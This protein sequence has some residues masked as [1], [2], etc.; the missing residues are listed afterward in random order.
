MNQRIVCRER[1]RRER[2]EER[3]R[4]RE[5]G[6]EEGKEIVII[7][8]NISLSN[9]NQRMIERTVNIRINSNTVVSI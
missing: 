8:P 3:E 1:E 5:R 9:N 2:E 6:R 4:E 7:T